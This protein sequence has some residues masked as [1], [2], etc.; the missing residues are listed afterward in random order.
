MGARGTAEGN[1]AVNLQSCALF[2]Y[3]GSSTVGLVTCVRCVIVVST[4]SKPPGVAPPRYC[5]C[6]GHDCV[7]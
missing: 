2:F 7:K 4:S 3:L 5:W 1:I 6:D